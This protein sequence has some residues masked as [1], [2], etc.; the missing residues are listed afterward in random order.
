MTDNASRYEPVEVSLVVP[1]P[2]AAVFRVLTDPTR[3]TDLDGSG[4]LRGA[5]TETPVSRVGDVFTMRMYF[6]QH[7]H[8]EMDNHVVE[9][10]QDRRIAWEPA[11]GRG[12]PHSDVPDSRWGHRWTYTLAPAGPGS[13]LVTES[14]DCSRVPAD[15]RAGM[16]DGRVWAPAMTATL[17]RLADAVQPPP[18]A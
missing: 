13:T 17:A 7:G 14:Y 16:E 10:E 6:A 2:P 11:P 8:Y 9:Y 18:P 1:A 12:H 15:E 5:V 3:H 4:M